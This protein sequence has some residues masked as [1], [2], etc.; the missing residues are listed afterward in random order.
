MNSYVLLQEELNSSVN[1]KNNFRYIINA[2]YRNDYS[3]WDQDDVPPQALEYP[4]DVE[5]SVYNLGREM[6]RRFDWKQLDD[7]DA[8]EEP[9]AEDV[10]KIT[11]E[12]AK[13]GGE[14]DI[15]ADALRDY[16]R[17]GELETNYYTGNG[18]VD[19]AAMLKDL[20]LEHRFTWSFTEP[21]FELSTLFSK[22]I[23]VVKFGI[24]NHSK[25]LARLFVF[26]FYATGF[27]A[28]IIP[29]AD[30]FVRLSLNLFHR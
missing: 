28:L 13:S 30:T 17:R 21:F 1:V 12:D 11:E 29:S 15:A 19:L 10:E 4:E 7:P 2:H 16:N 27:A 3:D 8:I 22:D 25:P 26:I 5:R 18:Y 9:Q 20:W 24:L 23:S 6:H 14:T